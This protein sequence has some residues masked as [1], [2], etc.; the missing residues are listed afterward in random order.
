MKLREYY[1]DL[2]KLIEDHPESLDMEMVTSIDDEGNGFN[3]VNFSAQLGYFD[4]DD[5]TP[6]V[7]LNTICLN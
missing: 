3:R 1:K 2:Q 6:N 5:F 4:G 7:M